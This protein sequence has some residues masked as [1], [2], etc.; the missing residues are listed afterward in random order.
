MSTWNEFQKLSAGLSITPKKKS[1]L[2][3]TS[4]EYSKKLQV[5]YETA[6]KAVLARYKENPELVAR[7]TLENIMLKKD[8]QLPQ[9]MEPSPEII[10]ELNRLKTELQECQELLR[11]ERQARRS[12]ENKFSERLQ[13]E[14]RKKFEHLKTERGVKDAQLTHC[15][16]QKQFEKELHQAEIKRLNAEI[17]SK[18]RLIMA[19]R[20]SSQNQQDTIQDRLQQKLQD[21]VPLL[22]KQKMD[23]GKLWRETRLKEILEATKQKKE[24]QKLQMNFFY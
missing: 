3:N 21:E 20:T 19:L 4:I 1:E 24:E 23:A 17:E 15:E 14:I 12:E 10:T 9:A 16:R 22:L 5:P 18:E 11:I 8:R 13:I 2:Y 6:V 7:L